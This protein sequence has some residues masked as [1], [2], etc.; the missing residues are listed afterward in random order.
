MRIKKSFI[1]I[2]RWALRFHG[3]I[4][5]IELSSALYE[6]AY[7]TAFIAFIAGLIEI[8]ASFLI[9]NE[10]IHFKGIRTEVHSKCNDDD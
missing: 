2:L 1:S 4:H 9:P 8:L 3:A 5:L 6:E 7:I 10:H